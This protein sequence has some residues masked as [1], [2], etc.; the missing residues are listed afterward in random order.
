MKHSVRISLRELKQQMSTNKTDKKK[1]NRICQY[2]NYKNVRNT[3]GTFLNKSLLLGGEKGLPHKTIILEGA[4]RGGCGDFVHLLEFF[5]FFRMEYPEYNL[6]V[7]II[8]YGD[9]NSCVKQK[10]SHDLLRRVCGFLSSDARPSDNLF[11]NLQ[12][13]DQAFLQEFE[14]KIKEEVIQCGLIKKNEKPDNQYTFVISGQ[15][16]VSFSEYGD[17]TGYPVDYKL[18]LTGKM[19]IRL[20]PEARRG[21][22]ARSDQAWKQ[23]APGYDTLRN[24]RKKLFVVSSELGYDFTPSVLFYLSHN[25]KYAALVEK[26]EAWM[27]LSKANLFLTFYHLKKIKSNCAKCVVAMKK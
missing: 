18:G 22:K 17:T 14:R 21:L 5:D 27:Y 15:H 2:F 19:G 6:G 1:F 4:M 9:L 3:L 16:E 10:L 20:Y 12:M 11:F 13:G 7:D 8:V 24:N 23:V 25:L 26:R